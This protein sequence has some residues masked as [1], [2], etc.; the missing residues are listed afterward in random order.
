MKTSKIAIV[1]D[2]V[3]KFGGAEQVLLSL[4]RLFPEAPLYT[5]V[6]D[7][8]GATW[9]KDW[10]VQTS[11]L[12]RVPFAKHHHEWFG[13][14]MPVA[15]E[16]LDLS[17][18]DIIISVT[19]EA[20]KGVITNSRQLHLC[21][22]LTPTRYL[23]SHTQEY[24]SGRLGWLKRSVFSLLREWDYI[25]GQRP[26]QIIAISQHVADRVKKYYGREADAIL[27]PPVAFQ[28]SRST[29]QVERE[30][31]LV[32]SRLVPYKKVDI[33]IQACLKA[34]K[35]LL[36][37]GMGSDETRLRKIA[38][39]NPMIRFEGFVSEGKLAEYYERAIAL[40][41][42]QEEDFG[43]VSVEAQSYGTPVISYEKSGMVETIIPG[44]TGLLFSEALEE[45]LQEAEG[46]H[47]DRERI[48]THSKEFSEEKFLGHWKKL[49]AQY[50][51]K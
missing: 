8:E 41:C 18:F 40:I 50:S 11:F 48:V 29:V 12:Q 10:H 32:V 9:A 49:I 14:L 13:W 36:I 38:N 39:G 25:A 7:P 46:K 22:C 4:H 43:I 44:I 19:S 45:T 3:N 26:D 17:P 37:V 34:H 33:A 6:Y 15:F 27:Y 30:Y 1:Y 5:S 47:W 20:G 23:W 21:Y 24:G 35:K 31:F 42:P 16:S 28:S 2:R 51:V